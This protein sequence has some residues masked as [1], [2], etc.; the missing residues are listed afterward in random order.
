MKSLA[1]INTSGKID[2]DKREEKQIQYYEY[3]GGIT[4]CRDI[5]VKDISSEYILNLTKWTNS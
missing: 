4:A 5:K 3:K 2:Q 1:Q